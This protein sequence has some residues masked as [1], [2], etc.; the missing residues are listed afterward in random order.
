M[1]SADGPIRLSEGGTVNLEASHVD[2]SYFSTSY[3]SILIRRPGLYYAA[4]TV[5]IPGNTEVDTVM[6]LELDNQN[7]TPPEIA[8]TTNDDETTSNYAGHTVFHAKAG[9]LLKLRSLREMAVHCATSQ[10]V[11]TL[12]IFRIS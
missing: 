1:F 8:V 10:P 3:G 7:I 9:S 5:D 2:S 4:V 6:R 11:F 12:T